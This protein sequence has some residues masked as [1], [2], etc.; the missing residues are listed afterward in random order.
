MGPRYCPSI[1]DK[2]HRFKDK[3]SHHLFIEPQT[4]EASEYYINGFS[5]SLPYEVQLKALRSIKGFEEAKITRF[6]YA[7]EYDYI[8]P[9]ELKHSLE[10]KK[11]PNLYC[12]GQING[13]TGYEEAAAQGFMAA[14]NAVLAIDKKPAF[15]LERSEAYIGVMID[16]LVTKGTK[17]PYRM[18]T[19]RAEYRLLLSEESAIL[20]LG[21]Y[22]YEFGL[23]ERAEFELIEGAK[24]A[25]NE[26]LEFLLA[27]Q[28]TPNSA[29]NAF[30]ESLNE[31]KI[32][33]SVSL[34][35]IVA[36]PSF[37][38]SKLALL[39]EKFKGLDEYVLSQILANAKYHHY[40]AQQKEQIE[41]MKGLKELKIPEKFNFKGISGLSNEVVE[42]LEK[43]RPATLYNASLIS[44][45]TPAALDI[46]QI[47]IKMKGDE[48]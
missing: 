16:D 35:K 45:I 48:A 15:V 7:I 33:A 10:C 30:L 31:E 36:R 11:V 39:D 46:L 13:T 40:I 41:K 34:Q 17:E 3:E 43:A 44:G 25:I 6:G 28:W 14:V 12:A 20:R 29:N 19:S 27:T 47:Y 38:A 21:K 32:S 9:T 24:K 8:E 18:F 22:G 4:R 1:E 23:L 5:T 26:G 37:T 42:K 2:I